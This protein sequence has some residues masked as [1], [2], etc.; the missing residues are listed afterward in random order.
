M[1]ATR[2]VGPES[3]VII[4]IQIRLGGQTG[5]WTIKESPFLLTDAVITPK[6][7]GRS[8]SCE[9]RGG[10]HGQDYWSCVPYFLQKV[11]SR[12]LAAFF[13]H[14]TLLIMY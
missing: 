7:I 2:A 1:C 5:R 11:S 14:A 12:L 4:E 6:T 10:G 3:P 13:I 9:R 8:I